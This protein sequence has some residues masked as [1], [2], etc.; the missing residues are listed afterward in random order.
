M[1]SDNTQE[2]SIAQKEEKK[3]NAKEKEEDKNKQPKLENY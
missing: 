1:G 3:K 2:N